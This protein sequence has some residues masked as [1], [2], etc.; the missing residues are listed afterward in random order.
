MISMLGSIMF[1]ISGEKR[2]AGV[3]TTT[4][5][6]EEAFAMV[7]NFF[8]LL[9]IKKRCCWILSPGRLR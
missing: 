5:T 7:S 6:F 4:M 1:A 8:V 3:P 2:L 9:T